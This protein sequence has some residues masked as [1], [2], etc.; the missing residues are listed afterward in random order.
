MINNVSLNER[1]EIKV[2][3]SLTDQTFSLWDAHKTKFL[4]D[5][6]TKGEQMATDSI[7]LLMSKKVYRYRLLCDIFA[8]KTKITWS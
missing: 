2:S 8:G 4:I 7:A 1:L 5:V 3:Q 6:V